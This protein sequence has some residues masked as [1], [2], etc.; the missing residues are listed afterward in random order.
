MGPRLT[1]AGARERNWAGCGAMLL[2]FEK[3]P[4]LGGWSA[5]LGRISAAGLLGR[6][7]LKAQRKTLFC[8]ETLKLI[9]NI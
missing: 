1:R 6:G 7:R 4:E 3:R 2:G 9:S 5:G 8:K